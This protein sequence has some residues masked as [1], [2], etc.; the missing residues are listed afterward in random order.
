MKHLRDMGQGK[1]MNLHVQLVLGRELSIPTLQP[2][3]YSPGFSL[4]H[5]D[6][7]HIGKM[8]RSLWEET[9]TIG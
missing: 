2:L 8:G 5:V 9:E 6:K 7:G 4:R 1:A 3:R